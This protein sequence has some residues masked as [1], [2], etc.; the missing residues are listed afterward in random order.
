[1]SLL[2]QIERSREILKNVFAEKIITYLKNPHGYNSSVRDPQTNMFEDISARNYRTPATY[3]LASRFS[4]QGIVTMPQYQMEMEA[5]KTFCAQKS[6]LALTN[7]NSGD[8]KFIHNRQDEF[9]I[10]LCV[11]S[12]SQYVHTRD[13]KISHPDRVLAIKEKLERDLQNILPIPRST[14]TDL[15]LSLR[16]F[17]QQIAENLARSD[18]Q[19]NH[20]MQVLNSFLQLKK[21]SPLLQ[22]VLTPPELNN[23][24]HRM[25]LYNGEYVAPSYNSRTTL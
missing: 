5:M 15:F 19:A 13:V 14:I 8:N 1:M 17:E 20:N 11:A 18:A 23:M 4:D 25:S 3:Q 10:R 7:P 2:Q 22:D 6:M 21:V 9:L 16:H 24:I 12:I